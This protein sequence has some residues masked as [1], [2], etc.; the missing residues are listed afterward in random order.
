LDIVWDG[1]VG[2][3]GL[4]RTDT[5]VRHNLADAAK[6]YDWAR[7][8]AIL[9]EHPTLVNTIRP[10]GSSR[11]A[12]LHQAAHGG[13]PLEFA[14]ELIFLGAWRTLQNARGERPIDVAERRGRKH[15]LGVMEPRLK[16][17]VPIGVLLRIQTLF[18]DVIL[19]RAAEALARLGHS[20]VGNRSQAAFHHVTNVLV[21]SA[22]GEDKS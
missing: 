22:K 3:D 8:M 13:A 6:R 1:I 17:H 19:S 15:L 11:F 18:H 16:R 7:M 2:A 5:E 4:D 9:R 14:E 12:P 10:G 20:N 21:S